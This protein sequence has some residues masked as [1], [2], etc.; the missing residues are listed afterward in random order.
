MPGGGHTAVKQ[1][2]RSPFHD[3]ARA[4]FTGAGSDGSV[5]P[6]WTPAKRREAESCGSAGFLPL[7]APLPMRK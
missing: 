7:S 2:H 4:A 5:R 3:G 1:R 6:P